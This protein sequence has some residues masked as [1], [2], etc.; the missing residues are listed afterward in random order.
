MAQERPSEERARQAEDASNGEGAD[1]GNGESGESGERAAD[2]GK[3]ASEI[4]APSIGPN[5]VIEREPPEERLDFDKISDTDAM[6]LDKRRQVVGHSYSAPLSKQLLLYGL[7]L[8]FVA[9]LAVGAK[10]LIDELD[11][12]P[13]EYADQAPWSQPD[14]RQIEPKPIQ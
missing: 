7:F 14:A 5:T 3:P 12:P 2:G 9:A 6:G 11:A 13:A 10:L 4:T 1:A 8:A